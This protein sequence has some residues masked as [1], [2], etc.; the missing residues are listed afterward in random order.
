MNKI[1]TN[2]SRTTTMTRVSAWIAGVVV[3]TSA[4]LYVAAAQTPGVPAKA[5][6]HGSS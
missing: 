4:F 1:L 6:P 3:I 5:A 2:S